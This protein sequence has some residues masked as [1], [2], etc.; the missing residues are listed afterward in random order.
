VDVAALVAAS[1]VRRNPGAGVLPFSDDVVQVAINPRDS[2]MTNA[3]LL[4]GL[5][6]G[7]TN[8][9]APLRWLNSR[10]QR[11]DLLV[12]VSDNESWMDGRGGRGGGIGAT[13]TMQ[14]WSVFKEHNPTARLVCLDLQPYGHTQA[15]DRDDVLNIGG[16]SDSVFDVIAKFAQGTDAKHWTEVISNV[17]V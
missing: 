4:A 8:C 11:G 6:S 14:Q 2:V 15:Q 13:Q 1:L 7:G 5:P 3:A 9:S 12:Y 10:S 16:F 17:T